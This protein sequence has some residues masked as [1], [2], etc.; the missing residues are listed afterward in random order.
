MIF[1]ALPVFLFASLLLLL[2]SCGTR[3]EEPKY[4]VLGE[5]F[6]GPNDLPIREDLSLRSEIVTRLPH[7]ARVEVIDRRRRFVKVRSEAGEIGWT[8]MRQLISTRQMQKIDRLAEY[9]KDAPSQGTATVFDVLNVHLEANR[10]SPTF[11]QISEKERVEIVGHK[12]VDRMPYTGESL[13]LADPLAKKKGP[14]ARKPKKEPKFQPPPAPAAPAAPQDWE[15]LSRPNLRDLRQAEFAQTNA[16][17]IAKVA[18]APNTP[19][20]DLS[21][22]RLKN[23]RVGWVITN[24]LFLEVPDEVAQY[25]EGK[26]IAAYFP[27][28]EVNSDGE[29][30]NHWLWATSSQRY[31]PF[32]FDDIR[33]FVYNTKRKRYEQGYREKQLR[34]FFPIQL[35][36]KNGAIEFSVILE[37]DDAQLEKK[38]FSFDGNRVRVLGREAFVEPA[39]FL[40]TA[41]EVKE[42][43]P[44]DSTWWDRIRSLFR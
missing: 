11:A 33:L 23:G 10:Y 4:R 13:D 16:A 9:Y 26:R 31:S 14:V 17:K 27:M 37:R 3:Q 42:S 30:K 21:L 41:Q 38:R 8:D 18:P 5:A 12:V 40:D 24:A 43:G 7:G 29:K 2:P 22:V 20:D 44:D 34:G 28:G 15:E 32:D 19:K 25:A 36:R 6:V 39:P 35:E 1:R